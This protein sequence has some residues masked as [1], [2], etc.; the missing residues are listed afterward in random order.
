MRERKLL[1]DK[2]DRC[3]KASEFLSAI[4]NPIRIGIVC[5]LTTGEKTVSEIVEKLKIPQPTISLN[6]H[7][8]YR[9]GWVSRRK[10]KR[11]VYYKLRS[12][13]MKEIIE[14]ISD[15]YNAK[16]NLISKT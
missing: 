12:E 11:N 3:V 8:L 2:F 1:C 14:K 5:Y 15:L 13:E 7:R 9:A 16:R 10:V 6:L 4:S